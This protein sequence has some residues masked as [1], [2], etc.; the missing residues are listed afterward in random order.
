MFSKQS[1]YWQVGDVVAP[2][3][4]GREVAA[5]DIR[6][7]PE[8]TGTFTHTVAAGDRLD[9]LAWTY[10][11][12]PLQFW[13]ICDANPQFLSPLALI[14]GEPLIRTRFPITGPAG[15]PAWSGV[16]AALCE[17]VGVDDVLVSDDVTLETE[18][19]IVSGQPVQVTVERHDRALLVTYNRMRVDAPA[20][21]AV[22]K[23]AGLPVGPFSDAGQL[24][25]PIIV[26][27]AAGG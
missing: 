9:Q 12:Q 14:G 26:P 20:L 25:K 1:R 7:L 19:Q 18:R 2:D 27:V 13:R 10:Y 16:L 21:V 15:E 4:R 17:V 23:G 5:K 8:V 3:S 11:N 6:P 22:I 24:G